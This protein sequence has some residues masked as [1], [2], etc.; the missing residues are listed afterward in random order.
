MRSISGC[1]ALVFSGCSTPHSIMAPKL[2]AAKATA[3]ATLRTK[4]EAHQLR[5]LQQKQEEILLRFKDL[6]ELHSEVRVKASLLRAEMVCL[7][8]D[9]R[10]LLNER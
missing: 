10:Q 3:K 4:A 8:R 5:L 1:I 2:A 6:A 7:R 9:V